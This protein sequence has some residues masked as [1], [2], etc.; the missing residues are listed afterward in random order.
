[1]GVESGTIVLAFFS[2]TVLFGTAISLGT[3]ALEEMQLRRTPSARDLFMI[4]VAA[5]VENLGYR[6]ANLAFRLYGMWRFFRKD[7]RWAAAGR[8]GFSRG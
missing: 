5:V 2:I 4:G 8:A 3:L 1:M 7:S 6:Q